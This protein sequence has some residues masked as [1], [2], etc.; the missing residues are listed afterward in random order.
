MNS[1][2][3]YFNGQAITACQ[4]QNL[5]FALW[6]AGI[7]TLRHSVRVAEPRGLFCGMGVCQECVVWM[8]G[9][10]VEACMTPVKP[11]LQASSDAQA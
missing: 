1:F 6:E 8:D 10:R 11:E 7:H 5:A 9:R 3:I 4:G 2:R